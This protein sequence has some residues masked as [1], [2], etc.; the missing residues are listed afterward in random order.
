M[1]NTRTAPAP[2]PARRAALPRTI[3]YM[4]A[5]SRVLPG[6]LADVLAAEVPRG[7][8]VVDL[9][10]GTAVVSAHCAS[11]SR[12][13]AN[14]VQEYARAIAAG[15]IE[16]RPAAKEAFLSGLDPERDLGAA[17]ERNVRALERLYAPALER[18]A[19]LLERH[20]RGD[21]GPDWCRDYRAFLESPG[22]VYGGRGAGQNGAGR[23]DGDLFRGARSLLSEA[24]LSR[25]RAGRGERPACLLTAYYAGIYFG[26]RQAIVLDSLRAAIDDLDPSLPHAEGKRAHY[27]SALLHTASLSTS[28]TSHFA[29]PRHLTKESE[30]RAMARRRSIDCLDLFGE[31]SRDLAAFVRA[32]PF[33]E[34]NRA[35]AR[36]YRDFIREEDGAFAFPAP[37]DLVYFDPP[38]TRDNYSRFYHVLEALARYDYPPLERDHR[39]EVVRGRYQELG[40]RF[41]SDFTRP[42]RVEDE[43]RRVIRASAAAGAKL[44]V[45]YGAPTG[46]LLKVYARD[47]KGD[48]VRRLEGLCKESYGDVSTLRRELTHSGQGEAGLRIEELLVV[49]RRP[50]TTLP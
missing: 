42:S 17:R 39:G 9:M 36:D 47:G 32:T 44:V 21:D 25:Y 49:C 6:F 8:T 23:G 30:L 34:G 18:E 27:L 13:F 3:W 33:C 22:A 2:A 38:Y 20:T 11:R 35:S 10:S 5:K 29:Q 43:F 24:S 48:P 14:D 4:G 28:G 15:F 12:V 41:N 7:G 46:L 1:E 26:L 40:A 31:F 45:S 37:V 50:R 16:H 19:R